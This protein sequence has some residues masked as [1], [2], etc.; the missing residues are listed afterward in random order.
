MSLFASYMI[1]KRRI[2]FYVLGLFLLTATFL[3]T[4]AQVNKSGIFEP[5]QGFLISIQYGAHSPGGDM[6]DRFEWNSSLGLDFKFKN[7]KG[8][9]FGG[10][11][12]W[13]FGNRVKEVGM[14]DSIIGLSDEIIDQDGLF[15]QVRLNER[16]HLFMLEGGKLFPIMKNNRNSGILVQLGVGAMYHRIDIFASSEKVPQ[17]TGDYE[18]GY[19]RLS[20]GIAFN[21]FI[22]YQHLD[23]K[24]Q[25]NF[26]I[27]YV[28]HQAFTNSLR[29]TQFDTRKHD[30]VK[31]KDLLSGFRIGI[32]IPIYTKKPSVE[33]F[34]TD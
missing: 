28:A 20:G 8:W 32:T 26:N 19:D 27:G 6:S 24:K 4:S 29:T 13:G 23:P 7:E 25:V 1:D 16:V 18:K 3:T 22:G 17:I 11:Y 34:F 5:R 12:S 10:S 33:E 30:D 15:S 31:R 14:F 2:G 9:L 21:Q